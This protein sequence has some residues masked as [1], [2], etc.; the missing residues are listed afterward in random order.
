VIKNKTEERAHRHKKR[1]RDGSHSKILK[2]THT[3]IRGMGRRAEESHGNQ[4]HIF[5]G[6]NNNRTQQS[7]DEVDYLEDLQVYE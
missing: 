5:N 1:M 2:K 3:S 4:N 7:Q 6:T